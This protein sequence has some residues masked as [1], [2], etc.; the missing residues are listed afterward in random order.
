MGINFAGVDL[1]LED[2]EGRISEWLNHYLP[3]SD[4]RAITSWPSSPW[5]IRGTVSRVNYSRI[6]EP[7][8]NTWYYPTGATRWAFGFF[9]ASANQVTRILNVVGGGSQNNIPNNP[10]QLTLEYPKGHSRNWTAYLLPPHPISAVSTDQTGYWLLPIVDE[11]WYWQFIGSPFAGIEATAETWTEAIDETTAGFAS[12]FA[13]DTPVAAYLTGPNIFLLAENSFENAAVVLDCLLGSV[14]QRV[15]S[16]S[17]A[18]GPD[19]ALGVQ[20]QNLLNVGSLDFGALQAGTVTNLNIPALMPAKIK[21][22]FRSYANGIIW[23]NWSESAFPGM[24]PYVSTQPASSFNIPGST[25]NF[26]MDIR[27]RA[28]ADFTSGMATPDNQATL[29]ALAFRIARDFYNYKNWVQDQCII[30]ISQWQTT[31]FDD[32]IEYSYGRLVHEKGEYVRT[33]HTRVHSMPYNFQGIVDQWHFDGTTWEGYGDKIAGTLDGNL[34]AGNL[35]TPTTQT[36]T[37]SRCDGPLPLS[38]QHLTVSNVHNITGTTGQ[39]VVAIRVNT[40][41]VVISKDCP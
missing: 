28:L 31:G 27:S 17:L 39:A 11:R 23:T 29:D 40:L 10:A 26:T 12:G 14:G 34:I 16:S 38:T 13:H 30:G 24:P 5:N 21:V 18:M 15:V 22:H 33:G 41:W 8:L 7:K 2:K 25:A 6:L 37:V 4:S 20:Q 9:L 1:L 32:Y 19:T 35:S 36:I 3:L